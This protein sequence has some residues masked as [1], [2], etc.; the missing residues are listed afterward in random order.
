VLG[1]STTKLFRKR[2]DPISLSGRDFHGRAENRHGR[3]GQRH[4]GA[5]FGEELDRVQA[6]RERGRAGA[7]ARTAMGDEKEKQGKQAAGAAGNGRVAA[8]EKRGAGR[9][10]RPSERRR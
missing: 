9:K 2:F 8:L 3:G 5:E 7:W 4:S 6:R 10:T 1:I